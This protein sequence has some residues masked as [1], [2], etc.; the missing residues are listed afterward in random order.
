MY[1]WGWLLI[2]D[3]AAWG[4]DYRVVGSSRIYS[5]LRL[6]LGS[7]EVTQWLE[8]PP[9][10]LFW[11]LGL[12]GEHGLYVGDGREMWRVGPPSEIA[13]LMNAESAFVVVTLG[14]PIGFVS[15]SH[16]AWIAGLGGVVQFSNPRESIRLAV[17]PADANVFPAG[18]CV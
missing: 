10:D 16:G 17:G 5:V 18:P 2:D 9:D 8:A 6:D 3:G 13:Q 7:S 12:D 11:P 14:G 1:Q 15:D 4:I